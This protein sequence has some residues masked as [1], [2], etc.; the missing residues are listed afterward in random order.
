MGN[1]NTG[2]IG[3]SLRSFYEFEKLQPFSADS[4][5][6]QLSFRDKKYNIVP[7]NREPR[8]ITVA[9]N[10][11][12]FAIINMSSFINKIYSEDTFTPQ[13]IKITKLI[14][15]NKEYDIENKKF[16]SIVKQNSG[17]EIE[18][19]NNLSLD[20]I[21][22]LGFLPKYIYTTT[23]RINGG[24]D[25]TLTVTG[26]KDSNTLTVKSGPIE[27]LK[28]GMILDPNIQ[29]LN[30]IKYGTIVTNI[31][32]NIITI[33]NKLKDNIPD[34]GIAVLFD[35]KPIFAIQEKTPVGPKG[36]LRVDE[37]DAAKV[38]Y[39]MNIKYSFP[40]RYTINAKFK[41]HLYDT[42][43]DSDSIVTEIPFRLNRSSTVSCERQYKVSQPLILRSRPN[44]EWKGAKLGTND[45]KLYID[46]SDVIDLENERT[47]IETGL[48]IEINTN[49]SPGSA[50]D[51]P[52]YIHSKASFIGDS[53]YYL[54]R[55]YK[56]SY[57][58]SDK[59]SSKPTKAPVNF[60]LKYLENDII[61]NLLSNIDSQSISIDKTTAHTDECA[62]NES[63][64]QKIEQQLIS[65][66]QRDIDNLICFAG[67][68]NTGFGNPIPG[69]KNEY[70]ALEENKCINRLDNLAQ[71]LLTDKIKPSTKC[72]TQFK[73][74]NYTI[75]LD[76][77]ILN[78]DDQNNETFNIL[79]YVSE[80]T[81]VNADTK[82]ICESPQQLYELSDLNIWKSV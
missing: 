11:N 35:F 39:F 3:S 62:S 52:Y 7:Q 76:N 29:F 73:Y 79:P 45:G 17:L 2:K 38:S 46:M 81:I 43:N 57:E 5:M 24:D 50:N 72:P 14:I 68:K 64:S 25:I 10:V 77:I 66:I 18:G 58:E 70:S 21:L 37:S 61:Y 82:F 26:A 53:C 65:E 49:T 71:I 9:V 80:I 78:P 44:I 42:T 75:D 32:N 23:D 13:Q 51:R 31:N 56:E 59:I 16:G 40:I 69:K 8:E 48:K 19:P 28:V 1:I 63:F 4:Q 67:D 41:S 36:F 34:P 47:M 12:D 74:Y 30:K 60:K 27:A 33:N 54:A 20:Q 55:T 15:K 22:Q 6:L